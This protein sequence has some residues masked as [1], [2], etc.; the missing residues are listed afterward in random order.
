MA[1]S[2]QIKAYLRHWLDVVDDHSVHSP[3]FYDFYNKV[4]KA[5]PSAYG[6]NEI[7]KMRENLS[8]N[9]ATIAVDDMGAGSKHFGNTR[10]ISD[11]VNTS[12]SPP[13]LAQ[14]YHRIITHREAKRIVE[15][16]TSLGL[17]SL[18]LAT[19]PEA[20]VHTFEGSKVL[21]QMALTHFEYFGKKNITLFEGDIQETLPDFLQDPS[22]IDFALMDANHRYEPTVRY[23][24]WMMRRFSEKTIVVVDDIHQ[25]AEMEKAW[26]ELKNH[27]LVYGSIDLFRCG[28]LFFDP[29]LNRQHFVWSL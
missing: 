12:L 22:K 17:T 7:E 13:L 15:L 3:Y 18:Y 11:V 29:D 4:L 16:G 24:E 1:N 25:S 10:K 20:K 5:T 27:D 21:S 26:Q 6:F 28:V 2:H 8:A 9:H 23:F 14:F 19:S